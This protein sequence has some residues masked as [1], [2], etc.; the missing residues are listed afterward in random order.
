MVVILMSERVLAGT[1]KAASERR[2]AINGLLKDSQPSSQPRQRAR[3]HTSD[4]GEAGAH[5]REN[6]ET[7]PESQ[8]PSNS[9]D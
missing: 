1:K 5:G 9:E 7:V 3:A 6:D 4:D 8:W 2:R